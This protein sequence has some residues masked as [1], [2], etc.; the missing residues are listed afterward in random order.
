MR[1]EVAERFVCPKL[2]ARA[3]GKWK[4]QTYLHNFW[5][6]Q[7]PYTYMA[8]ELR[9]GETKH[10]WVQ[11]ATHTS[12]STTLQTEQPKLDKYVYVQITKYLSIAGYFNCSAG[13]GIGSDSDR[14]KSWGIGVGVE[15]ASLG[16][17]RKRIIQ[18]FCSFCTTL[19]ERRSTPLGC[20]A[21]SSQ[22]FALLCSALICSAWIL[23]P[24]V[25]CEVAYAVLWHGPVIYLFVIT[26]ALN[27][28]PAHLKN[29]PSA[30]N[31]CSL[32]ACSFF[33]AATRAR[34]GGWRSQ[35]RSFFW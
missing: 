12:Y 27:K 23:A 18:F 16:K 11:R 9:T 4:W 26:R 29:A 30:N 6:A 25:L 3:V 7:T 15:G 5:Q 2:S 35:K 8:K 33:N 14:G 17:H 19:N 13:R 20:A 1:V 32:A 34:N 22:V 24:R 21:A 10:P 28:I 31:N